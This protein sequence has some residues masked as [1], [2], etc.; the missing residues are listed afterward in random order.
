[1]HMLKVFGPLLPGP[2][3]RGPSQVLGLRHGMSNHGATNISSM[4]QAAD[5]VLR[6]P[7]RQS[8]TG[9]PKPQLLLMT[10]SARRSSP[11][12]AADAQQRH[13]QVSG[14]FL[15]LGFK[16]YMQ[17]LIQWLQVYFASSS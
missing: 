5:V 1:M 2:V 17:Q 16:Y 11:S 8:A 6:S 13:S 3:V 12:P 14:D 9:S 7:S 15:C 4:A 10:A